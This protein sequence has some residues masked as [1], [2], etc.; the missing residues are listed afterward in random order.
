MAIVSTVLRNPFGL[1][2]FLT[3][4]VAALLVVAASPV[5][6]GAGAGRKAKL[7][8]LTGGP[9]GPAAKELAACDRLTVEQYRTRGVEVI[10]RSPDDLK[11]WLA[12]D[13]K[14]YADAQENFQQLALAKM[15][16]VDA[17]GGLS[18]WEITE[19][20]AEQYEMTA[21]NF[22][23]SWG[24]SL[25]GCSSNFVIDMQNGHKVS[26]MPLKLA[27][28]F[29]DD[30]WAIPLVVTPKAHASGDPTA[31]DNPMRGRP[32]L[33]VSLDG[34]TVK[35][36]TDSSPAKEAGLREGDEVVVLDG[37]AINDLS[38]VAG[39][40]QDHKAGDRIELE[41]V[42][43][44]KNVKKQVAL[45]DRYEL[46]EVKLGQ[47]GKPLP[48]LIGKDIGGKEVRLRDFRGKVVLVD[49]WAT[50]CGPCIEEMPLV[51]L[52]W[53]RAKDKGFVWI[54]VSAD[55][56]KQAWEDYV[57]N[58]HLGGIQLRDSD[59]V[60]VMHVGSFPTILLVDTAGVVQAKLRGD[61]IAQATL[62][63]LGR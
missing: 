32:Y 30:P 35:S 46:L 63:M 58:N 54:G 1:I 55:E 50:W 15:L 41:F 8:Y 61:S 57:K 19:E 34:R 59:W 24:L 60:E 7:L 52:L 6:A 33:G 10:Q 27:G 45:A 14:A 62:A 51:Q 25:S 56:D 16:K 2:R 29:D 11:K 53:E 36:V 5:L 12:G 48:D 20:D 40:L 3:L 39:V 4:A 38:D 47:V 37:K 42:H 9:G 13:G 17:V 49:F 28:A 44:G 22:I 31:D 21:G 23:H 43:D 18:V 26:A